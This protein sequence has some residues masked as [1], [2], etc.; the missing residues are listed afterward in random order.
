MGAALFNFAP[1]VVI[2]V[3]SPSESTS[4]LQ[5][6]LDDYRTAGTELVWVVNPKHR[7]VTCLAGNSASVVLREGDVLTG[8]HVLPG[9]SCDVAQIFDGIAR[10]FLSWDDDEP[11]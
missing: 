5:E 8:S 7:T 10:D 3:R 6:K 9:F 4:V 11:S 2:E 1:D